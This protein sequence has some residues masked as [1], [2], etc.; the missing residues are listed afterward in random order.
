MAWTFSDGTPYVGPT[1][2]LAGIN[3]SG[4]TRTRES[5][6]LVEVADAPA[7]KA[8]PKTAPKKKAPT[9]KKPT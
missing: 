3:Y 7:P 9:K 1:H 8:A 2:M 4:A 5:R 6:R